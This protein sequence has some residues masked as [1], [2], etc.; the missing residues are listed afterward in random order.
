MIH[1][2]ATRLLSLD[3]TQWRQ[4]QERP[5]S[6]DAAEREAVTM[7]LYAFDGT[8]NEDRDGDDRD[9]NVCDFFTRTRTRSRTT[10]RKERGSLYH[11]RHRHAGAHVRRRHVRGGVRHRRPPA[12]ASGD[13][14]AREQHRG[15]RRD[16]DIVGFSR[17]AA[18][19]LSFAN[20]I[21][22]KMPKVHDPLH[23]RCSMSSASSGCPA[24]TS[25]PDTT[26]TCRP[27]SHH[28]FHAMA[29]DESR[30]CS[31]R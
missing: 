26:C 24:S 4:R 27:T 21:A 20:E 16:V 17:G 3:L 22:S 18:L 14:S 29:L 9:S 19:A 30:A 23:R 13:G 8:G 25:T 7:A 5:A 11:E 12:R 28:F 6:D 31:F 15:R 10:T 1:K 2:K